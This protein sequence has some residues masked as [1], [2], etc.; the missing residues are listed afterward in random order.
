LPERI[1][2]EAPPEAR[3]S[4]ESPDTP[5][6]RV[7]YAELA[8]ARALDGQPVDQV[9]VLAQKAL[10]GE[11]LLALE[12]ADGAGYY[13]ATTALTICED[14][15]AA[16]LALT[17]AIQDARQRGSALGYARASG[18]RALTFLRRGRLAE[19]AADAEA[20]VAAVSRTPGVIVPA[21]QAVLGEVLMER[22]QLD[23]AEQCLGR[24]SW[25]EGSGLARVMLLGA[26]GD[27]RRR[28]GDM[29]G[30]LDAFERCGETLAEANIRNPAVLNWRSGA[31][32]ALADLGDRERA[33]HLLDEELEL[34][35]AFG[36]PGAIG[37]A[38]HATA[39]IAAGDE[40][41][42]LLEAALDAL[43]RSEKAL[44]RGLVLV[45]LGATLRRA[46]T[47]RAARDPL[48]H[49]LDLA[50]RCGA[51]VLAQRARKELEAAGSRPRRSALFGTEALTTRERQVAELAAGGMSN[52]EI[53]ES[54]YVTLKTVEWHLCHTF[55]KLEVSSRHE[56][57]ALMTSEKANGRSGHTEPAR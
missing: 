53:A 54:L 28:R 1:E 39:L 30:A 55:R 23:K 4:S 35:R 10:G 46:G 13:M 32:L 18:F 50:E 26:E 19:A 47:P 14:Y 12:T 57:A 33:V 9:R 36:A 15:Q 11:A 51:T 41:A 2:P 43:E 25:P 40:R 27:L 38:L 24:P 16:E 21:V 31:A 3:L 44:A 17:P 42:Q 8:L 37:S 45:E 20:A 49:G 7:A 56:L 6:A 29:A 5:A 34:A 48:R 22:G 52:R